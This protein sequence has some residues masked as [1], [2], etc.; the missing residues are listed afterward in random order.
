MHA[1]TLDIKSED[2]HLLFMMSIIGKSAIRGTGVSFF[3]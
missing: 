3:S 2:K 1:F